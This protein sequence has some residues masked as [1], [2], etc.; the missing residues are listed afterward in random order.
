MEGM[1]TFAFGFDKCC[2]ESIIANEQ[3]IDKSFFGLLKIITKFIGHVFFGNADPAFKYYISFAI[4]IA[5]ETPSGFFQQFIYFDP[6]FGFF[7]A[8]NIFGIEKTVNLEVFSELEIISEKFGRN[9]Y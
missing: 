4:F 5:K 1:D 3:I 6:G 7:T 9:L 8:H 2:G